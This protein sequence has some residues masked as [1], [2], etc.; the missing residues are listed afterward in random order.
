MSGAPSYEQLKTV[1][2]FRKKIQ[3]LEHILKTF[4]IFQYSR[5]DTLYYSRNDDDESI[6]IGSIA[7]KF[8]W[9]RED[10]IVNKTDM[11]DLEY[12]KYIKKTEGGRF[13]CGINE[14]SQLW[15]KFNPHCVISSPDEVLEYNPLN[16]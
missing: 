10:I 14:V 15:S 7:L 16:L 9:N 6:A 11:N 12:S 1:E 5:G 13:L 3:V 2:F 8:W 4:Y